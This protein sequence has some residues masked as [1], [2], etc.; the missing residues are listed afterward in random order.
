VEVEPLSS[1]Q[2]LPHVLSDGVIIVDGEFSRRLPGTTPGLLKP[3]GDSREPPV[4]ILDS[5]GQRGRSI[6][7][8]HLAMRK[9]GSSPGRGPIMRPLATCCSEQASGEFG[10]GTAQRLF[11]GKGLRKTSGGT[12]PTRIDRAVLR[13][14]VG[15][16]QFHQEFLIGND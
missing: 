9:S 3:L 16:F 5:F 10:Q 2:A 6:S 14:V 15:L 13:E 12:E 8:D 1:I 4:I 11:Y 7:L